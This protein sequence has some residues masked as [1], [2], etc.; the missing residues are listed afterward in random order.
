MHPIHAMRTIMRVLASALP[1]TLPEDLDRGM[2]ELGV[3][4]V[5]VL[6]ADYG[7][8]RL[9]S[10]RH[11]LAAALPVDGSPAGRVFASQRP[12]R[13]DDG[14]LL[15]PVS[16]RGDRR[17]V[18]RLAGADDVLSLADAVT[19]GEAVAV[20][21]AAA[22]RVTDRYLVAARTRRLTVAAEMQW[23][24]LPGTSYREDG[25]ELAALLEPAYTVAGDVFDW[26][27][28]GD[29][30]QVALCDG[31]GTGVDAAQVAA[32]A[33]GALRNARRAG[34]A[35]AD[36]AHLADQALYS[37]YGGK[38]WL[39]TLLLQVDLVRRRL[40]VVDAGSPKLLRLP[41]G[42]TSAQV[43]PLDAQ[44]PLG[45]F[46]D[47]PYTVQSFD[48]AP[49]DRLLALTDGV[50]EPTGTGGTPFGADGLSAALRGTRLLPAPEAVR[51]VMRGLSEHLS[52][53]DLDD[54]AAVL[55]LD[56]LR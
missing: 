7:Q 14:A 35:L 33:L 22:D 46:E 19:L 21:L 53:A 30:V 31:G 15:V 49:G 47:T 39:P 26:S 48:V 23:A 50:T 29:L 10:L 44:L 4:E 37:H 13:D 5:D 32:V 2:R 34:A 28:S 3:A 36:Q 51:W 42:A 25:L 45:M 41:A 43:L 56:L 24:L 6:V 17:G 54:D 8:R 52:G 55:C 40:D 9:V 12:G 18:L 38:A 20:S 11:P 16:A 1:H 27:R